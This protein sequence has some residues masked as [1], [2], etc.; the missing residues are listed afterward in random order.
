MNL[1][2]STASIDASGGSASTSA[3]A[4]APPPADNLAGTL[5]REQVFSRLFAKPEASVSL[6][7][8]VLLELIGAG[9]MGELYAAYDPDLDRKVALK[10][11]RPE[12]SASAVAEQRLLREAQSAAR[13]SHPNVVPIYEVGTV[14]GRI[15][16]AMEFI[17]GQDLAAW[18]SQ[19]RGALEI[20]ARFIAAGEGLAAVHR[21]G[22]AHRDFKPANVLLGEDGRVRIVDFGLAR[23]TDSSSGSGSGSRLRSSLESGDSGSQPD[24]ELPSASASLLRSTVSTL[25]APGALV[26]T[27]RFMAPEQWRARRGDA[28]SD[29]FSFCV[30]LYAALYGVHPFPARRGDQLLAAICDGTLTKP[31][32][33]AALPQRLREAIIRGLE[34]DP[35]DRWP[36]MEP[37]LRELERPLARPRKRKLAAL[38]GGVGALALAVGVGVGLLAT[39][40]G[41]PCALDDDAL[42]G[43]WDAQIQA[44]LSQAFTATG[45]PY[46][47]T[48]AAT[49]SLALDEW[50]TGWL[51]QRERSC[52]ATHVEGTQSTALLD[53][54]TACLER[55]RRAFAGVVGTFVGADAPLLSKAEDMLGALPR[56]DEC[57]HAA[58][59]DAPHPLPD[60]PELR[61]AIL[62]DYERL[63]EA[64][65]LR[66]AGEVDRSQAKIAGVLA[67]VDQLDHLPLTLAARG[68]QARNL[69]LTDVSSAVERMRE[70]AAV[71]EREGLL[72]LEAELRVDMARNAAGD[73]SKPTLEGWLIDD[74]ELALARLGQPEDERALPLLAARARLLEQ[75]GDYEGALAQIEAAL[76]RA[77]T[78]EAAP[79]Q[80]ASLRQQQANLN[81]QLGRFDLAEAIYLELIEELRARWGDRNLLLADLEYN[82]GVLALD[83]GDFEAARA[84]LDRARQ[85]TDAS[86]GADSLE[87]AQVRF[88]LAKID[89]STGDF[90]AAEAT[91][92]G[93]LPVLRR[94]HGEHHM[95]TARAHEALGVVRFYTGDL[96]GS[97]LS[98]RTALPTFERVLGPDSDALGLL[99][100]NIGE[101]LLGLG[102]V[103]EAAAAFTLAL[104]TLARALPEDHPYF[105]V[106]LKARGQARLEL[107]EIAG[108]RRDLE[109]A[110]ALL[111]RNGDEPIELAETRL[112]LARAALLEPDPNPQR[113]RALA[114]AAELAFTELG[115]EDRAAVAATVAP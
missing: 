110:R 62:D 50:S 74:A 70:T 89:L 9:G 94:H 77:A 39:E 52:R 38:I 46:A 61:A 83:R 67:H 58:L 76:E 54:R 68:E 30:A 45:K 86:L 73:L 51:D 60:A 33:N 34:A 10:L 69:A 32:R 20:L 101:S 88:V 64:E 31:A 26:G 42:A 99:H 82:L 75:A 98:Y 44:E 66:R 19:P 59:L 91:I 4:A 96:D 17:R 3:P 40:R 29:Q 21:A 49:V 48:S 72:N 108:A 43:T 27:P 12:R 100:S 104:D 25:T 24:A 23:V 13:L 107:G 53:R 56:L 18:L 102:R 63:S 79:S 6:G 112:A 1:D 114:Q 103:D 111:E 22:L 106:P 81:R 80:R 71:A 8:F 65:A 36:S 115:L 41:D 109:A 15:F 5:R 90:E 14:D 28:R 87:S 84:R 11:V 7:R 92:E 95:Q 85:I 47:Q 16:V 37:L 35:E 55:Q 93:L 105:G 113:A 57:A 97:L 2:E 78:L